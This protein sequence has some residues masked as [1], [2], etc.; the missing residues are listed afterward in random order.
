MTDDGPA[1]ATNNIKT[2]LLIDDGDTIV[3]GGVVKSNKTL[4]VEGFPILMK[5]P[6]VGWLF[7]SK[8]ESEEKQELLI[9]LTPRIVSFAG[10]M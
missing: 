1:I 4:T 10:E 6:V 3:I 5:I 7:K 8:V 9:F 2:E